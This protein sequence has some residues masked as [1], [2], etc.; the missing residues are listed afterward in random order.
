ME[1]GIRA[2]IASILESTRH[3]APSA[4]PTPPPAQRPPRSRQAHLSP[5]PR[6][7]LP[8]P[9]PGPRPQSAAKSAPQGREP[10]GKAETPELK[11]ARARIAE[12]E[13]SGMLSA[14]LTPPLAEKDRA[15]LKPPLIRGL[16]AARNT[17]TTKH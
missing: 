7:R 1:S 17:L 9:S 3:A 13:Q 10:D 2:R 16:P 15:A 14:P 4:L 11:P 8:S 5:E 12:L 6:M